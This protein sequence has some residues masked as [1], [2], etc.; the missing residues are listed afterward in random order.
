MARLRDIFCDEACDVRAD[1]FEKVFFKMNKESVDLVQRLTWYISSAY[2]KRSL[3]LSDAKKAKEAFSAI[4]QALQ[5][6]N[7]HQEALTNNC[8][9]YDFLLSFKSD[10]QRKKLYDKILGQ[11]R[12][13][14]AEIE[15]MR[16][17]EH[18]NRAVFD[19]ENLDIDTIYDAMDCCGNA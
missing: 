8:Q 7:I 10:E 14:F 2:L 13:L 3:Q 6:L 15:L 1:Y 19:S 4:N 18:F 17:L 12:N 16:G 5:Y 11:R 9:R